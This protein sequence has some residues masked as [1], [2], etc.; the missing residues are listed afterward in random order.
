MSKVTPKSKNG[1]TTDY[2]I[3]RHGFAKI[4]EVEGIHLTNE[5]N[6]DFREFEQKGLSAEERRK[7]IAA[8]YGS[9]S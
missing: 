9:A 7:A 5:M 8:K 6:E 1:A 4:S 2:M 3:G